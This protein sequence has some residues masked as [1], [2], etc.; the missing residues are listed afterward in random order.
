VKKADAARKP[1]F[2]ART[3]PRWNPGAKT[4]RPDDITPLKK[5]EK[6]PLPQLPDERTG[7]DTTKLTV[8]GEGNSGYSGGPGGGGGGSYSYDAVIAS[9]VKSNWVRPSRAVVGEN[10]PSVSISIRIAGDGT[11][12]RRQ[13]TRSSGIG[14]LDSSAIRAIENSNPLPLG[15]PS[16]IRGRY[17]DVTI[18]FQVTDDA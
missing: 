9:V 12:T 15:L 4:E 2:V 1:V 14:L 11:I 17:Y 3:V 6:E 18:V 5:L 13:I 7:P 8:V 10:P 16:Y